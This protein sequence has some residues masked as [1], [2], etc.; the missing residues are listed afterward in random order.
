MIPSFVLKRLYSRGSLE[1][2]A[3]GVRFSLKNRLS[4][5]TV[6][7]IRR[8]SIDGHAA[9]LAGVSLDLGD[10][11]P[12][13]A[14][15]ISESSPLAFPLRRGLTWHRSRAAL[16]ADTDHGADA[17][18]LPQIAALFNGALFRASTFDVVGV[19]DL[20]LF[21]RGDEV[22]VH[23]RLVRSGLAFGTA[24]DWGHLGASA[25]GVLLAL[26]AYA[27]IGLWCSSLTRSP[28]IAAVTAIGLMLLLYLFD[29]AGQLRN[30]ATEAARWISLSTH[31]ASFNEG[32][33]STTDVAY[34]LIVMATFLTLTVRRLDADRMP[35]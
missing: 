4:D 34:Y 3:G 29:V 15:D 19:P 20:R 11:T 26:G 8:V 30:E 10:G 17:E 13:P 24:L 2:F 12:R 14:R 33:F 35:R 21:V 31:G 9:D 25:L 23:R 28:T 22:E 18:L 1:S 16:S 6:T 32:R 7:G 27:A 5:A